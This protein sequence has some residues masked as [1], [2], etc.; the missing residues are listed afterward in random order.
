MPKK[1][2]LG[3]IE[4]SSPI[5]EPVT[6]FGGQ[7]VWIAEPQWPLSRKRGEPMRFIGQ[8]SLDPRLFRTTAQMAYLFM[9]GG[10]EE[11]FVDEPTYDPDGGENAVILQ[12]GVTDLPT[13]QLTDG[14]KLFEIVWTHLRKP[15]EFAAV[16]REEDDIEFVSEEELGKMSK[17]DFERACESADLNENKIGGTPVFM[18]GDDFPFAGKCQLLLQLSSQAVPF[19]VKFGDA[20]V[21]YAFLNE[22]GDKAKFLW[23][24]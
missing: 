1:H 21:G 13:R 12:A 17:E 2:V 19:Y 5:T 16:L 23:Q 10:D 7:P 6:K 3:F 11:L 14:P 15:C 18:Q 20:G 4:A 24:S 9:T 8:I 22:A